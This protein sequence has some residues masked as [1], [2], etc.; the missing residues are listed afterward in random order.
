MRVG[1]HL[2][3]TCGDAMQTTPRN[4]RH[5]V[6]EVYD[7]YRGA[8]RDVKYFGARLAFLKGIN[9]CLEFIVAISTSSSVAG[10]WLWQGFW[11]GYIWKILG[12]VAVVLVVAKPRVNLP[13]TICWM[14]EVFEGYKAVEQD[15]RDITTQIRHHQGYGK[16]LQG[17]FFSARKRAREVEQKNK[18]SKVKQKL[19]DKCW[20]EVDKELPA[21]E[22][23][24]PPN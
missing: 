23:Y 13:A 24:I 2:F 6:W 21:R 12:A 19:R 3:P 15:L 8:K 17:M 1:K 18:E 16:D 7:E 10:L 14:T 9:F 20:E 4:T 11:G 5:L 22:F